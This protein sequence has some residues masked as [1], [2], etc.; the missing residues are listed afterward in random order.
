MTPEPTDAPAADPRE[1][2]R[3]AVADFCALP[4]EALVDFKYTADVA[5]RW[6]AFPRVSG[7][8]VLLKSHGYAFPSVR[9]LDTPDGLAAAVREAATRLR[10]T[11]AAFAAD[12]A[13]RDPVGWILRL[14]QGLTRQAREWHDDPEPA[15]ERVWKWTDAGVRTYKGFPWEPGVP[16]VASGHGDLCS[17]GWLHF[18]RH[19]LL[20]A[21]LRP[22]HVRYDAPLLWEA[23]AAGRRR[24]DNGL[25]GGCT[26]LT[27]VRRVEP[28]VMDLRAA[29]FAGLVLSR[30]MDGISVSRRGAPAGD[31][32]AEAVRA[33]LAAPADASLCGA[34]FFAA[35]L[36]FW[37]Y[38]TEGALVVKLRAL[39]GGPAAWEGGNRSL[40]WLDNAAAVADTLCRTVGRL[41]E[42]GVFLD[43]VGLADEAMKAPDAFDA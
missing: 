30:A 28:P 17:H 2:L 22:E 20:A 19:P 21:V 35:P 37:A 39:L 16:R 15:P 29:V 36:N 1:L 25:K 10:A 6:L 26:R 33:W 42:T 18:Y 7:L 23:E 8:G 9:G 12:A 38:S 41:A 14:I 27:L 5:P 11:L 13:F 40:L 24:D 34:A 4:D 31:P 3:A 32:F 43:L